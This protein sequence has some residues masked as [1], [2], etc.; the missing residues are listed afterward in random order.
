M[1]TA[2]AVRPGSGAMF[3][4]IAERYDLVNRIA[5]LGLDRSWRRAA[6]QA[7]ALGTGARVL[8][9]A[10]GTADVAIAIARRYA[11]ARVVGIDPSVR[12]L[13]RGARKLHRAGLD[14]R[15]ELLPG[16]AM[17]LPFDAESF[18]AAICAFGIRNV[19]DREAV[20]REMRRVTRRGGRVVVLEL[21]EPRGALGRIARLHVHHVVPWLGAWLSSAP[22]YRYLS[23][24][25]AAFPP[26]ERFAEQMRAVG[27][28]PVHI[29]S[30][31]FGAAWL[32]AA[33]CPLDVAAR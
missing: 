8:D 16:D 7:L 18:D 25:I 6:I 1:S 17:A 30:L 21:G 32:F 13:E 4:A 33:E 12:M 10:T 26:P 31:T 27:L 29:R 20:L 15:V 14:G 24:S 28:V 19:P 5:S 23:R 2:T 9:V 11:D 22:A 3:D